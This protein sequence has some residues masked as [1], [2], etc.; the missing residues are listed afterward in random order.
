M[1]GASMRA[2]VQIACEKVHISRKCERHES[3]AITLYFHAFL[4]TLALLSWT[5]ASMDG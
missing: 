4:R 2:F 1:N 3:G 5:A